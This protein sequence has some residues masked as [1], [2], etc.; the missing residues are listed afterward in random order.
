MGANEIQGGREFVA[1]WLKRLRE[2][3]SDPHDR[4]IIVQK[5]VCDI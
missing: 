2:A 3:K 5:V 4:A 1:L